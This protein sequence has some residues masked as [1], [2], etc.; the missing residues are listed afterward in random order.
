MSKRR[1]PG[2]WVWLAPNSGFVGES[3]RLK[4]EIQPEEEADWSPCMSGCDDP[5]CREWANLWTEPDPEREGKR[6]TLCHVSECQM[7]DEPR[8][9][10]EPMYEPKPI[11]LKLTE[12]PP[13][14]LGK[15]PHKSHTARILAEFLASRSG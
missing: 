15:G 11:T 1:N 4:A 7:F 2:D 8:G 5:N 9:T 6:H 12:G 10:Y 13:R 14:N 3:D